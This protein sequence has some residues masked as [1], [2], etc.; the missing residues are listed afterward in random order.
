MEKLFSDTE[1]FQAERPTKI[2]D[3]QFKKVYTSIAEEIIQCNLSTSN[4]ETIISDLET[5]DKNCTGFEMATLL[6]DGYCY[7]GTYETNS[8]LVEILESIDS[9]I[10]DFHRQNVKDWVKARNIKP[11]LE[12]GLKFEF[13]SNIP[14]S[15]KANK[16]YYITTINKE[17]AYYTVDEDK[18]RKGGRVLAFE[19]LEN[20]IKTIKKC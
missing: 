4:I 20:N 10:D 13:I 5:L 9:E 8:Q 11:T 16:E 6:A 3:E 1:V 7:E 2:T 14:Y 19:K 17:L 15:L 18:N 12:K